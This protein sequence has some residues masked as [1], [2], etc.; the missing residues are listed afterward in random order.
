[1]P[2][3]PALPRTL[4]EAPRPV[5]KAPAVVESRNHLPAPRAMNGA[6][7]KAHRAEQP[8]ES[9]VSSHPTPMPTAPPAAVPPS[10]SIV[11][12]ATAVSAG[13]AAAHRAYVEA[14]GAAHAR[15]L[16]LS[17]GLLARLAQA[18]SV[19][20]YVPAPPTLPVPPQAITPQN[21]VAQSIAPQSIAPQSI[22]PQP[23][24]GRRRSPRPLRKGRHRDADRPHSEPAAK[25]LPGPK[26]SR[27]ELEVLASGRSPRSSAPCSP[28]RTATRARCACPSRRC[29]SPI[30]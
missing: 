25:R 6:N 28:A 23:M 8:L 21:G 30:A 18:P 7:G 19:P 26:F 11:T 1:M 29:C 9:L 16:A 12:R 22:A 24:A 10:P 2:H 14:Q 15:F 17:G 5:P 27:A 4:P 3:A 20:T 13:V